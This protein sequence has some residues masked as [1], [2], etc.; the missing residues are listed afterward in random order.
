MITNSLIHQI[1]LG[2]DGKNWV[3][4]LLD[5]GLDLQNFLILDIIQL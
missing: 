3:V 4:Q 5:N 2:R 1:T